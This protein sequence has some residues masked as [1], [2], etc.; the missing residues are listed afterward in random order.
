LGTQAAEFNGISV[1]EK[2][3]RPGTTEVNIKSSPGSGTIHKAKALERSMHTADQF[4]TVKNGLQT[5]TPNGRQRRSRCNRWSF[6]WHNY[7][8][9]NGL[10][11]FLRLARWRGASA[12]D[13]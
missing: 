12:R 9:N 3:S 10:N 7:C 8:N 4:A 6:T 13:H 5:F 1:I 2:R 11:Y